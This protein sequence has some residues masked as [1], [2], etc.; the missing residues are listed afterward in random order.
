MRKR[1]F[2]TAIATLSQRI[3]WLGAAICGGE[4]DW[5]YTGNDCVNAG[6]TVDVERIYVCS[7]CGKRKVGLL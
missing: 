7:R 3:E 5:V 6:A 1:E 4:H 2:K